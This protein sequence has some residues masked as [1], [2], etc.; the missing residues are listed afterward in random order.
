VKIKK[1]ILDR[2]GVFTD[3]EIDFYPEQGSAGHLHLLYGPNEAG[4]LQ[5]STPWQI[6]D[7]DFHIQP[8]WTS[9]TT[10]RSWP[11]PP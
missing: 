11:S 4:N 6:C 7:S 8:A 3:R 1:L 2:Y 5:R 9:F 10:H